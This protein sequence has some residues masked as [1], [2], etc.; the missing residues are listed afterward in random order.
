[1]PETRSGK[2]KKQKFLQGAAVLTIGTILVK[3]IGALYKIPMN[4]IIG[5]EGFGHFNVAYSIFNVLLT[6]STTG[7]PIALSRMISEAETL[8]QRRQVQKIYQTSFRIFLLIGAVCSGAMLIFAPQLAS[9]MRDPDAVYAIAALAPAVLFLC[10]ISSFRGYFQGQQYMT[11]T[12]VSQV[13]EALCKLI[14][15]LGAVFL[16]LNLGYGVAEAAGGAIFGVT[17]GSVLACVYLFVQYRK[18]HVVLTAADPEHAGEVHRSH[19]KAAFEAGS[20][21]YHRLHRSANL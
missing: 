16:I 15:G 4:R 14:V 20:T 12:A 10:I 2:P 17:S 3:L 7:L 13:I 21:H 11:P 1:M 5:T 9:L 19:G 6:V 8:G 18:K